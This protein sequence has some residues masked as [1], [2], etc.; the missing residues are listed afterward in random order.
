MKWPTSAGETKIAVRTFVL[1]AFVAVCAV[2]LDGRR[3]PYA[4]R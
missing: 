3:G 2:Q 1:Q 4:L